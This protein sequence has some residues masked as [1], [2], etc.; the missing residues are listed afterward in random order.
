MY[1]AY[2]SSRADIVKLLLIAGADVNKVYWEENEQTLLH[3]AID[4]LW[5][6][7][8]NKVALD[9]ILN[10]QGLRLIQEPIWNINP[11]HLLAYYGHQLEEVKILAVA[12]RLT[13][14]ATREE[15]NQVDGYGK[16]ALLEA[17]EQNNIE[18]AKFLASNPLV[19][20]NLARQ[21]PMHYCAPYIPIGI[22]PIA[23]AILGRAE[24]LEAMLTRDDIKILHHPIILEKIFMIR[25]GRYTRKI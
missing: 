9:F 19:E 17:I 1:R 12:E 15:L 6:E 22:S 5:N 16:T 11:L 2:N 14:N 20:I 25:T 3:K 8:E 23:A 10:A 18:I 7:E 24:I 21:E 4:D 13:K